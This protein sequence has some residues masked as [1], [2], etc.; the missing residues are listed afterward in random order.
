MIPSKT[1][2]QSLWITYHLPQKKQRH[3]QLV[4]CAALYIATKLQEKEHVP[5]RT[6][7]LLAGALL[8]DIDKDIPQTPGE[9]HPDGAVKLLHQLDMEEVAQLIK[10][11][12]LHAILDKSIAP[13][14]LE[15]KILFLSDKMTKND[16]IGVDKRFALWRGE[17]L[18]EKEQAILNASYPKVKQLEQELFLRAEVN[19]DDVINHCKNAILITGGEN[20]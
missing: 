19:L 17:H 2:A 8:H 11:H 13:V 10:T 5:I 1:D 14:S 18:P 16:I 20:I 4:A 15:E 3:C 12:P 6:D 7:L 9:Q